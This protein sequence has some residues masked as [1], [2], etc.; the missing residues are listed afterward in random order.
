M[1]SGQ[2]Y[3]TDPLA[4][5]TPSD[6][7]AGLLRTPVDLRF[8]P[9]VHA[10][11]ASRLMVYAGAGISMGAGLPSGAALA[12]E[13]HARLLSLG[14]DVASVSQWDLLAVADK[15]AQEPGG[16]EALRTTALNAF[17]FTTAPPSSAHRALALLLLEGAIQ[18]LTTN[19]DTCVERAATP[20]RVDA[21]VTD[22]D[23]LQIRAESVLKVHGSAEQPATL[24]ITTA[25]LASPPIWSDTAIAAGLSTASVVFLGIG[26]IAPYVKERLFSIVSRLATNA[27][28]TVATPDIVSQWEDSGWAKVL[29]ALGE[30]RKWAL[31]AEQFGERLLIAWM[32]EALSSMA[33][34][35][36]SMGMPH[37]EAAFGELILHLG[38]HRAE[39]VLRWLRRSHLAVRPGNTVAHDGHT[40]EA[41]IA[42]AA[43]ASG[44]DVV[45]GREGPVRV[46][47]DHLELLI[48][49][50]MT[51]GLTAAR[52]SYRRAEEYRRDGVIGP[53]VRL[54]VVCAG[55]M[56]ALVPQASNR[57][58]SN[59]VDAAEV[60]DIVSG[61]DIQMLAAH[62]IIER[63]GAQ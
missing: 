46:G 2:D 51:T 28:V 26:D 47:D 40:A 31:T 6:T 38:E 20:E 34:T 60:G 23:R 62:E 9:L 8:V 37:L 16:E 13:I 33:S 57:L 54:K 42:L 5:L 52:E 58:P 22:A 55:H 32:R 45:I 43:L 53:A 14:L 41:L 18:F 19:W 36:R 7:D 29:P 4:S 10:G 39:R 11:R 25:D 61:G 35:V 12:A 17:P 21:V 30:N 49:P 3:S 15:A 56:G 48:A 63:G 1:N 59:L 44:R 24:L 27:D 50:S